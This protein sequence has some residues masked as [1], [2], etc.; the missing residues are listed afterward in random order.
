MT[1]SALKQ[2]PNTKRFKRTIIYFDMD[3]QCVNFWGK[4]ISQKKTKCILCVRVK[5]SQQDMTPH[6]KIYGPCPSRL[7]LKPV[8]N[9]ANVSSRT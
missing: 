4:G 3:T 8:L 1:A 6:T 7:L 2:D 9:W 5:I